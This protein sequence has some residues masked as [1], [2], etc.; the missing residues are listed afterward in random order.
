MN[1]GSQDTPQGLEAVL[2]QSLRVV[3]RR[4]GLT[5]ESRD[6]VRWRV[7]LTYLW[8]M[9]R[10]FSKPRVLVTGALPTLWIVVW[11]WLGGGMN[12]AWW[13]FELGLMSPELTYWKVLGAWTDLVMLN[14]VSLLM[15][16]KVDR[17]EVSWDRW[18]S[19]CC[20]YLPGLGIW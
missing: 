7:F 13:W 15:S 2:R 12:L 1:F 20:V 11:T 18:C 6:D 4:W 19:C 5:R 10:R 16:R 3:Q 14:V 8:E 9:P 17:L